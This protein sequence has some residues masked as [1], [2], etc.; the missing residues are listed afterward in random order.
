MSAKVEPDMAARRPDPADDTW[1]ANQKELIL[2]PASPQAQSR[3]SLAM[4]RIYSIET[5]P[6]YKP[7]PLLAIS[8]TS[9]SFQEVPQPPPSTTSLVEP[10]ETVPIVPTTSLNI[11]LEPMEATPVLPIS[12]HDAAVKPTPLPVEIDDSMDSTVEEKSRIYDEPSRESEN[13]TPKHKAGSRRIARA[14][15]TVQDH[16]NTVSRSTS[17]KQPHV[18]R[19]GTSSRTIDYEELE[20]NAAAAK[21]PKPS[22][23][24]FADNSTGIQETPPRLPKSTSFTKSVLS[25]T[26]PGSSKAT[27]PDSEKVRS[28]SP[29]SSGTDRPGDSQ[30]T[31]IIV[32]DLPDNDLGETAQQDPDDHRDLME[33]AILDND[34][35]PTEKHEQPISNDRRPNSSHRRRSRR[36][37]SLPSRPGLVQWKGPVDSRLENIDNLWLVLQNEWIS[38]REDTKDYT[39]PFMASFDKKICSAADKFSLGRACASDV[40][41][42]QKSWTLAYTVSLPQLENK[43]HVKQMEHFTIAMSKLG[44]ASRGLREEYF[45]ISAD[46]E[47]DDG[48]DMDWTPGNSHS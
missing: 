15:Q 19:S 24:A 46:M 27:M 20:R 6:R 30:K 45:R 14:P 11:E 13:S 26:D 31:A 18:S 29:G 33:L 28:H 23:E 32:E 22:D 16:S 12:I 48:D 10:K 8:E 42:L 40:R 36:T 25:A 9:V 1:P 47:R 44:K 38:L 7:A 41:K 3:S 37:R 21:I 34:R 4:S 43:E 2:S 17:P 35:A 5:L 39:G